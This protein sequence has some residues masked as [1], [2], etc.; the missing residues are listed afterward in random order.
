MPH[1]LE[2]YSGTGPIGRVFRQNE[3]TV[4]SVDIEPKFAP[5]ICCSVLDFTPD[6]IE[7]SPDVIWGSPPCTHYNRVRTT[8]KTPRDLEG[9]DKLVQKVLDLAD[10]DK[11][12][13]WMENPLGLLK[14]REVVRGIFMYLVD[15]CCYNDGDHPHKAR[16]R[17][18]IF[19]NSSWT[20]WRA[21]CRKDCGF[22]V[23]KKHMDYA[24]RGGKDGRPRHKLEE[25]YSIPKALPQEL[26]EWLATDGDLP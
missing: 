17:T 20:P 11:V 6:M 9:S 5:D 21:L 15:Y 22:C 24:Q 16:K 12:P 13:F 3:W 2:P 1:L 8:A 10:Y 14:D 19:T 23:G 25:L 26:C 18:C 4:T 7:D